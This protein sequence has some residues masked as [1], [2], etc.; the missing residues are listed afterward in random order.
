MGDSIHENEA[1]DSIIDN[2][3][4]ENEPI[5]TFQQLSIIQ[6]A[7]NEIDMQPARPNVTDAESIHAPTIAPD[8]ENAPNADINLD[9]DLDVNIDMEVDQ[10]GGGPA[11]PQSPAVAP[12]SPALNDLGLPQT[13]S[14]NRRETPALNAATKKLGKERKKPR[15]KAKVSEV[16]FGRTF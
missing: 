2:A 11:A 6:E 7:D 14:S 15:S 16:F 5:D 1:T 9:N 13:R 8:I 10:S 4:N 12:Q 3:R